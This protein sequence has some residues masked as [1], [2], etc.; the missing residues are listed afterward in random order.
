MNIPLSDAR[1]RLSALLAEVERGHEITITRRGPPVA[2]LVRASPV[3]DRDKARGT[4][5]ALREASRGTTLGG[6]T[7]KE[8]VDDGRR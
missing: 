7:I 4:A 6:V 8:F 1:N 5:K 2:K 3:F